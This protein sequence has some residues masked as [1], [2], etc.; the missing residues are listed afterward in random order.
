MRSIRIPVLAG[1]LAAAAFGVAQAATADDHPAR[2]YV[3]VY[4]KGAKA[5]DARAAIRAAGGTVVRENR[6]IGV[7]TVR[8]KRADFVRRADGKSA[9]YGAAN[10]KPIGHVP[11]AKVWQ[12]QW[13]IESGGASGHGHT[14]WSQRPQ[15]D[16]LASNQWDMRMIGATPDGSYSKQPGSHKV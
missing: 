12:P 15:D 6:A 14:S 4:A 8:S 2:D 16:P 5:S 11:N 1:V 10:N 9:I 3:V 7:A 13:K